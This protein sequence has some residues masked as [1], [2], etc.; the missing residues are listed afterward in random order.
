MLWDSV[1]RGEVRA[2]GFCPTR[3][4]ACC[5]ILSYEG[6]CVLWDSVLRGEVR[7]VGF[8]PTRGGACSGILS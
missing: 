4:G 6:R 3:G 8:C 7:A 1:L 5:G 2:V